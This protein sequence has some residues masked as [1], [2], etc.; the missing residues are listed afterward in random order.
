MHGASHH[1]SGGYFD[2]QMT[3]PKTY[4]D[5]TMMSQKT[6]SVFRFFFVS[7]LHIFALF[8]V[9]DMFLDSRALLSISALP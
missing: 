3:S 6:R 1:R 7:L 9:F 4:C 8:L 5:V 2:S